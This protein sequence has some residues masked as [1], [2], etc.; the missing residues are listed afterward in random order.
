MESVGTGDSRRSRALAVST[1]GRGRSRSASTA[2]AGDG[3]GDLLYGLTGF[4]C[5]FIVFFKGIRS[6]ILLRWTFLSVS[7]GIFFPC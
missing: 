3:F 2:T 6:T 5:V 7:D 1:A 4:V